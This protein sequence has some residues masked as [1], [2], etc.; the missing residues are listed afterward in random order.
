MQFRV[1]EVSTGATSLTIA[2]Q[3]ADNAATFTTVSSNVSSRLRTAATVGW[4]PASWPTVNLAGPNQRTPDLSAVIQQIVG[5]PG[6][7]SG[8]ALALVITGTGR[9][10]ADAFEDGGAPTL[11]LV[12]TTS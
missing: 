8:N 11:H 3:A 4:I 2:G 6:W 10:T 5:R 12:Y 1:D 7:V 9:R